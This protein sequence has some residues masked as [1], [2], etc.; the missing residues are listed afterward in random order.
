MKGSVNDMPYNLEVPFASSSIGTT[1]NNIPN[2][3]N[4]ARGRVL[5]SDTPLS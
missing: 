3:S 1:G 4:P 2:H 5:I